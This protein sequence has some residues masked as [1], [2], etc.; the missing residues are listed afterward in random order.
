MFIY[1][2]L[3]YWKKYAYSIDIV[4]EVVKDS[5]IQFSLALRSLLK[6]R[7]K[8]TLLLTFTF[9]C[10]TQSLKTENSLGCQ[11]R[12]EKQWIVQEQTRCTEQ[13]L[14]FNLNRS[15]PFEF[16]DILSHKNS[17]NL[18]VEAGDWKH[19]PQDVVVLKVSRSGGNARVSEDN[20]CFLKILKYPALESCSEELIL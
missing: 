6:D 18:S 17:Q 9:H 5:C 7:L 20:G 19:I 14:E 16:F 11:R 4:F 3:F 1:I 2:V 8:W 10:T 15:L 13:L 12:G